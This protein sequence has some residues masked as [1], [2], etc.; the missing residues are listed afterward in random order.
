MTDKICTLLALSMLA[1]TPINPQEKARPKEREKPQR[2]EPPYPQDPV[3]QNMREIQQEEHRGMC[4]ILGFAS[5][6]FG[7]FVQLVKE[8]DNKDN[9]ARQ[10]GNIAQNIF[11][12]ASEATKSRITKSVNQSVQFINSPEFQER[13]MQELLSH[14][15]NLHG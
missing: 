5:N 8:S 1:S 15:D 13:L 9:V 12:I 14:I 4:T 11:Y 2:D 6:I 3:H 10:V 7:N